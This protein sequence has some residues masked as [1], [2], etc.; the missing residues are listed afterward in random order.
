[1]KQMPKPVAADIRTSTHHMAHARYANLGPK[2]GTQTNTTISVDFIRA[3]AL[4]ESP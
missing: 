1:M 3:N 2:A 4:A